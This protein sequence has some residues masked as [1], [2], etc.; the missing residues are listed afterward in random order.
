MAVTST[1]PS[2]Q[3]TANGS[4]S[5]FAF[6]FVV[7][8]SD[9]GGTITT[10]TGSISASD[11]TLT[12]T[13]AD[14]FY[15]ADLVGKAITVAG[16]GD[17][18][19]TL[20]TT[21][22]SRTSGTVVELTDAATTTVSGQ[23]VVV[24]TGTFATTLLNNSDIKV[25]VNGV[26][27][28]IGASNDYT[29][30]LNVGD[31]ANKSGKVIFNSPPSNTS[32]ITIKRDVTLART[33][34][35]QTG[36]ALTAKTLNSEFDTMIMA[37]QDTQFES[38]A[39]AVKFPQDETPTSSFLPSSSTRAN[40]VLAF[41]GTGE[42]KVV[43][44]LTSGTVAIS[45]TTG[46][47]SS[48]IRSNFRLEA[49]N[50]TNFSAA[51][52]IHISSG[53]SPTVT[54][55]IVDINAGAIDDTT[56]GSATPST[57]AFTTLSTTGATTLRGLSYP[58]SDGSAGQV[59][60]T[61]G[62]GNLA[63]ESVAGLSLFTALTDTPS[64]LSGQGGKYVR[65]NSGGTALE[66]D[67]FTS[68]DATQG[69]NNIYFS[70]SGAAVNTTNL[71]EGTNL[72]YTNAR[73][74]ARIA[75]N[76]ID[77]DNFST[78]SDTRAPSQQSVK[79]Y[80]ATQIATKDNSDEITEGSTNLYF[81]NARA[82]GAVSVTDS[83]GDGSLAYNSSTGVFTY[84]GPSASE[85]RAH[86]TA[87]EGIDISSGAISGE[88]ATTSNKGIASFSSNNFDVSS[89]AVSLKADGI[90]DTHLDFGTGTNQISTDD[91]P[92]GANKKFFTTNGGAINT[93]SLV[94]GS[95]NLYFTNTRA[96]TQAQA[97][98]INN[99]VEDSTP[100][101]GGNLDT[102]GQDL[103]TTS[104]QAIEIKPDG[105]GAFNVDTEGNIEFKAGV[106]GSS[107]GTRSDDTVKFLQHTAP[108]GNYHIGSG[109]YGVGYAPIHVEGGMSIN[110]TTTPTTDLLYNTGIQIE[111]NTKGF[112][113]VA[114]KVKSSGNQDG[115][116]DRF[117]NIWF[118]RSGSDSGD[119]Y[120]TENATIGGFY[121][122]PYDA[123]DGDYFNVTAK[124]LA[125]ASEDHSDGSMGTMMQ[126]FVTKDGTK[127]LKEV[128]RMKGNRVEF[129]PGNN[130]IDLRVD[131]DTN[132]GVLFVDAGNERVGIKTTSPSVDFDVAGTFK[133]TAFDS[134]VT[135][136]KLGNVHNATP[137]DGQFLKYVNAN[138]RWEPATIGYVATQAADQ[139]TAGFMIK[140]TLNSTVGSTWTGSNNTGSDG[141]TGVDSTDTT[142]M[143]LF[144]DGGTVQ[145]DDN[146]GVSRTMQK[147]INLYGAGVFFNL[148]GAD[149]GY[150]A[151]ESQLLFGHSIA[152]D[153]F[154]NEYI[155]DLQDQ[156]PSNSNRFK[157][158]YNYPTMLFSNAKNPSNTKFG[159]FISTVNGHPAGGQTTGCADM[160]IGAYPLSIGYAS[161]ANMDALNTGKVSII[162]GGKCA[163]QS[164]STYG[165]NTD[166]KYR[167][168]EVV[169]FDMPTTGTLAG[170][171]LVEQGAR[172]TF[173]EP[174]V[175]PNKTTTER[176]ALTGTK[177]MTIF[178][179]T[180]N[181]IEYHD[182]SGW[183]YVSG[184][185]V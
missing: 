101:L 27:K 97:V 155:S 24:T 29:V 109:D 90:N 42:L 13:A 158:R 163:T 143:G 80:I 1:T 72:Y 9:T 15:T 95:T 157:R 173:L 170:G 6:T 125:T 105:T 167:I 54:I 119:A 168:K 176:N 114:F 156:Y 88:D 120:V 82:R 30:L 136:D 52:G 40:K 174:L 75:N 35:F 53:A 64:D 149:S 100:Q 183:K 23:T 133:A 106:G 21:I 85:V 43:D 93:D 144:L 26:E 180:E 20:E 145:F 45:A 91:I 115:G 32:K 46:T 177:G 58:S 139:V 44:D 19:A 141:A 33:T 78:D 113:A 165:G 148:G 152:T 76:L 8:A 178:N 73:A 175:L 185:S 4:T 70:T 62:N 55:P 146:N 31:D 128:L 57:G 110:G 66:F 10:S 131:G 89:G 2:I 16:A 151:T 41:D 112:P 123:D 104:N 36:G 5:E 17:S 60:K 150:T 171:N 65:V 99:V 142:G 11:Q 69:S 161:A 59:L 7:P 25:F 103:I 153:D 83:G 84:T 98:S 117:G 77:E 164:F 116:N 179:S 102:N 22:L 172:A 138:S 3:Y 63:F 47:F 79:A 92:E 135:L 160:Y 140:D 28:T 18:S 14:F 61:D 71:S 184:T 111:S 56:I 181:R 34:D 49:E 48:T 121:C 38:T 134:S 159:G 122:S 108:S 74:D 96:Q 107:F 154:G 169:K 37:I 12:V 126:W 166:Y 68:D 127:S 50:I 137:T 94:E 86:I 182:G 132:D 118:A 51:Q 39:G 162:V 87:G 67:T 81:T 129:N 124:F 130:N 147:D